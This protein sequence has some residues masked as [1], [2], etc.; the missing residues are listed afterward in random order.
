MEIH[1]LQVGELATNCYFIVSEN[2]VLIVDPGGDLDLIKEKLKKIKKENK[3]ILLTHYHPDHTSLAQKLKENNETKVLI[4]RNDADFLNFSGTGAD[5]LLEDNE[6][7][8]L[9]NKKLKVIH[10]PGHTQGSICVLGDNFII[11][12]DTLFKDGHGRTDL[13]GGSNKEIKKSLKKLQEFIEPGMMIY[14][15]HGEAFCYKL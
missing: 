14:P 11:T 7:I 10:T 1:K 3:Y 15:G 8:K 6:E 9:G 12:G 2:E 4:H 13:P 5:V